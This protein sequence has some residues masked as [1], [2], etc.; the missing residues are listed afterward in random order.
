[1]PVTSEGIRSG[2]NWMRLKSQPTERASAFASIVL[3][4][5]GTSSM[6][7]VAVAEQRDERQLDDGLARRR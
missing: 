5:P 3:P 2:V 7:H 6:Q 4:M 1:M